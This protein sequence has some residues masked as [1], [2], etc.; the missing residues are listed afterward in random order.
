MDD[1]TQYMEQLKG[2]E[3]PG[4]ELWVWQLKRGLYGMKQ[5]RRIWNKTMNKAMV[6]WGFVWLSYESCIYYWKV[7]NGIMM[8]AVHVDD[9]LSVADSS[10]KNDWFKAQMKE[11]WKISSSSEAK[12]CVGIGI[13]LNRDD[14]T[15]SLSK[16]VLIDKIIH[17]FGQ[18]NAYPSNSPMDPGLKLQYPNKKDISTEDQEC[19]SQLPCQSLVRC[20]IYL[21]VGT[22]PD[23]A[24][25]IQQL[26]QF[27]DSYTYA[28]WH[29]AIR[30]VRYLKGTWNLK[31]T[32]GGHK[33]I[34]LVGLTNL[35]WA[36]CLD[37]RRS[38]GG[39]GFTLGSGL[40]SWNACKQKMVATS[41][42]E[43]EYTAAFEAAKESIWL[44]SLLTSIGFHQNSPST[45][46]C[47]NNT[48]INLSED[49]SLHQRVK[50]I[51]I[52]Y[53]FLRERVNM[54]EITL[55]YINTNDNL[56]DIFTK[57]IEHQCFSRLCNLLGLK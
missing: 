4:K 46:L 34:E 19:F 48:T 16:M 43:A 21:S 47:D 1:E 52:K 50:H 51:N 38:V 35:D 26:S 45:I 41:S 6:S 15:V 30:V 3:Q 39:Y 29:A 7:E 28:H 22:Q 31:L 49:L 10:A 40:I 23:I 27:L 2:F 18:Q 11:I 57:A 37:T 14:H 13:T 5:S 32:L 36:N 24:Y 44:R 33:P 20:L 55:K 42:C 8:A 9:F 17:Q 25:A 53:H 56:A 54:G 12:F